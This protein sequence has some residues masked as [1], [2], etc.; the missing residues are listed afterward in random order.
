MIW[1]LFS[2]SASI[3][4]LSLMY[5]VSHTI[6]SVKVVLR[7]LNWQGT[8]SS[9][10]A[11]CYTE[12]ETN[13]KWKEISWFSENLENCWKLHI[14]VWSVYCVCMGPTV[15]YA[16]ACLLQS[17]RKQTKRPGPL[18]AIVH[19]YYIVCLKWLYSVWTPCLARKHIINMKKWTETLET[20]FIH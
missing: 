18:E 17:I 10:I 9:S 1:L 4:A 7:H 5:R 16:F 13:L 8:S 20:M 14:V 19:I 11:C 3:H 6:G 12:S 15:F 2:D